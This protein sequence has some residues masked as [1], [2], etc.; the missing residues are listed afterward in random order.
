MQNNA[1]KYGFIYRYDKRYENITK[2]RNEAWHYR[3]VGKEIAK[4]VHE[5]NNMSLDEYFV[6]FLDK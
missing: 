6:I 5:H 4:Y 3:Y 2:F 1:Y